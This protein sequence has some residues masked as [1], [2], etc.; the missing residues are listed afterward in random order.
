[1]GRV[2]CYLW[3]RIV[4][5]VGDKVLRISITTASG[6]KLLGGWRIVGRWHKASRCDCFIRQIDPHVDDAVTLNANV[7]DPLGAP[8]DRGSVVVQAISPSGKTQTIQLQP[9]EGDAIGLFTGSFVPKESGNYQLVASSTEMGTSVQTD[10]SVQGLNREQQGRLARFE[11]LDEIAKITNGK[12]VPIS[13]VRS[14]LDDLAAL[15]EPEPTVH[16]TRIWA[17]PLWAGLLILL[18]GVFWIA[19]KMTGAI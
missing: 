10:L 15:P 11:V 3:E 13:E 17:H 2:K 5:G 16:R 1:M 18:L 8:L 19:R 12:L 4:L 9:G 7:N 14:L 6:A